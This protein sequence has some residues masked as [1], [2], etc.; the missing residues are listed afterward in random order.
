M[1][2]IGEAG[3]RRF[4]GETKRADGGLTGAVQAGKPNEGLLSRAPVDLKG[5]DYAIFKTL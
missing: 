2:A 3:S 5:K 1:F 4:L